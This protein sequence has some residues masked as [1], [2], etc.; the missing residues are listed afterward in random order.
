MTTMSATVQSVGIRQAVAS[1]IK[2]SKII[3]KFG[4]G[5]TI[6]VGLGA[7]VALATASAVSRGKMRRKEREEMQQM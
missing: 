1:A 5:Q 6:G 3:T 4:L 2:S 7:T